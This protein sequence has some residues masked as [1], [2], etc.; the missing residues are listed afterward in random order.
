MSKTKHLL[1]LSPFCRG[2]VTMKFKRAAR[3]RLPSSGSDD[4]SSSDAESQQRDASGVGISFD[5]RHRQSSSSGTP[6][7]AYSSGEGAPHSSRKRRGNLPKQ[8]VKILKRW[9]FEHRYYA[10]PNDDEKTT[11]SR[12]AN[13]TVLQVCNWFINARRRI[14]PEMIRREGHDPLHYTITRRG[15]KLQQFPLSKAVTS[16]SSCHGVES[17]EEDAE[18]RS[19]RWSHQRVSDPDEDED[20]AESESSND[21][22]EGATSAWRRR[23]R[24]S[25]DTQEE[26]CPRRSWSTRGQRSLIPHSPPPL[27]SDSVLSRSPPLTSD[28]SR[29]TPPPSPLVSNEDDEF[30]CLYLLVE[31][32]VRQREVELSGRGSLSDGSLQAPLV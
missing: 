1:S 32:A 14:L 3:E 20:E 25:K 17:P 24:L 8:S 27:C 9:L 29:V 10:Y 23:R 7:R 26:V 13:L 15:K 31:A 21:E 11:L 5:V 4:P 22:D 30:K 28:S 2:S 12:E 19:G 6:T 16:L 18:G